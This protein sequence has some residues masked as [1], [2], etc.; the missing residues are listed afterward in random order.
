MPVFVHLNVQG[1]FAD[2]CSC[3]VRQTASEV[4]PEKSGGHLFVKPSKAEF[5][6]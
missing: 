6:L 3:K 4:V 2:T 5:M 1:Q